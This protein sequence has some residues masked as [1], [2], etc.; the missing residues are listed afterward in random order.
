ML[1]LLLLLLLLASPHQH[2]HTWH[3][4]QQR[5]RRKCKA[6]SR[7]PEG[8]CVARMFIGKAGCIVRDD[9]A[10]ILSELSHVISFVGPRVVV[11]LTLVIVMSPMMRC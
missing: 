9:H 4:W 3:G 2:L 7:S 5:S 11:K 1:L 8:W 6:S 10:V